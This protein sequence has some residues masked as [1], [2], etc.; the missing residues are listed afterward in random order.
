MPP[1]IIPW[2]YKPGYHLSN[3][4][5]REPHSLFHSLLQSCFIWIGLSFCF[6]DLS[7][8]SCFDLT[9]LLRM[10]TTPA[11]CPCSLT[12]LYPLKDFAWL[13][14][15]FTWTMGIFQLTHLPIWQDSYTKDNLTR[16]PFLI[17]HE[18]LRFS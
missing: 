10:V 7:E 4:I 16:L 8:F 15:C 5:S 6:P 13:T 11:H 9:L 18:L 1:S 17:S 12:A 14:L 3:A 2:H